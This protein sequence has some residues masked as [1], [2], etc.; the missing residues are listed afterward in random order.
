[1]IFNIIK[2]SESLEDLKTDDAFTRIRTGL[3]RVTKAEGSILRDYFNK[4]KQTIMNLSRDA[5]IPETINV[6]EK[7]CELSLKDIRTREGRELITGM[8]ADLFNAKKILQL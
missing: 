6:L 3:E 8:Q 5:F 2:T 1:S 4:L 7:L